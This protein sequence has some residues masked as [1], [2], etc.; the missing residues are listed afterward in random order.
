MHTVATPGSIGP[1]SIVTGMNRVLE[2]T[3][4]GAEITG[5]TG[6][7][8]CVTSEGSPSRLTM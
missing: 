7:M 2:V 3:M 8:R 5:A 4:S 1:V 6:A